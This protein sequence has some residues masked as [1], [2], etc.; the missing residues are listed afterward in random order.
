ML[1]EREELDAAAEARAFAHE[2]L[3][4]DVGRE[5]KDQRL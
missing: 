4:F 2:G 1:F 3:S 5:A